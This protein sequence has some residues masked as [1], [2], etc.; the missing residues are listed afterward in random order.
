MFTKRIISAFAFLLMGGASIVHAAETATYT[1]DALGRLR[2]VQTAGGVADGAT[3]SYDYD[4]AG[5]RTQ[6]GSIRP[7][8]SQPVSVS[9]ASG[10]AQVNSVGTTFVVNI[11][12]ATAGGTVTFTEGGV[13]LG[14]AAVINGQATIVLEGYP[15]G[16]HTITANYSGDSVH[17][18]AS[19]T[20]Q[21]RVLNL[22]WL[23]AV[24]NLILE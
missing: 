3:V 6:H 20:Y 18:P 22:S 9:P 21:I 10:V 19:A 8:G 5:N 2:A 23:P 1:Y 15:L 7:T 12:S 16:L 4:A 17:A 14:S 11:G 13:F 24:L